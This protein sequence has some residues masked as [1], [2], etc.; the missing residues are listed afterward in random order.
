M[1]DARVYLPA[2]RPFAADAIV[3]WQTTATPNGARVVSIEKETDRRVMGV[4]FI[5]F[6]VLN[7]L[8]PV[9]S[10]NSSSAPPQG[11]GPVTVTE[12]FSLLE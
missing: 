5:G 4:D 2:L 9:S 7:E 3:H 11:G 12:P 8:F 6:I 10:G 1:D